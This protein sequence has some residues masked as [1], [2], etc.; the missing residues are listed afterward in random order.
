MK[1]KDE[2]M[3][4]KRID[5]GAGWLL[6]DPRLD[7]GTDCPGRC[8]SSPLHC[9]DLAVQ[10]DFS[11]IAVLFWGDSLEKRAENLELVSILKR[12]A[13]TRGRSV[14]A[15][16][17]R[18]NRA[19]L[20]ALLRAGADFACVG[21]DDEMNPV[22]IGAMLSEA[23]PGNGIE[24]QLSLACPHVTYSAVDSSREIGLCGAY[25]NRLVLTPSRLRQSCESQSHALCEYFRNP[26]PRA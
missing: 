5:G 8:V 1:S 22:R 9:L 26:R 25:R 17:T 20:E 4:V 13:L 3:S 11:V 23:G 21:N 18:R 14:A 6:L 24:A 16:C 15:V 2:A 19:L 12:N 7:A 10:G